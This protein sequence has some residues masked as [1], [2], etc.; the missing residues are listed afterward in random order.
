MIVEGRRLIDKFLATISSFDDELFTTIAFS[1]DEL[2]I[3]ALFIVFPII[4]C[5]LI[6]R[7]SIYFFAPQSNSIIRVSGG[8]IS[9]MIGVLSYFFLYP[10]A[11]FA[12]D[13]PR[14]N[15]TPLFVAAGVFTW[16]VVIV[17][18]PLLFVYLVFSTTEKPWIRDRLVYAICAVC[19][20]L[21]CLYLGN[22]L[23]SLDK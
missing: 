18:A 16:P 23:E 9:A 21:E 15:V 11:I 2:I 19:V 13:G 7:I 4:I 10:L 8:P 14:L 22:I 6:S 5:G 1:K 17:M 12:L 20:V 3:G